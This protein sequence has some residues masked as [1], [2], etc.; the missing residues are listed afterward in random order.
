MH[1]PP[2]AGATQC[3]L[4]RSGGR[5][6]GRANPTVFY[7]PSHQKFWDATTITL[8]HPTALAYTRDV[9]HFFYNFS[10]M[11]ASVQETIVAYL[12]PV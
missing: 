9:L 2:M 5:R 6:E 7:L 3:F 10:V 8:H 12:L 1:K 11:H 4:M